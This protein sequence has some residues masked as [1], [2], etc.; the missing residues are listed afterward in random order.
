M[1]NFYSYSFL[2][3]LIVGMFA[4]AGMANTS[5]YSTYQGQGA[6]CASYYHPVCGEKSGTQ[7]VYQNICTMNSAGATFVGWKTCRYSS[8]T[9]YS[10]NY[11][12]T[13]QY[14]QPTQYINT[15][16]IQPRYVTQ[17]V[18]TQDYSPVCAEINGYKKSYSN[19]CF[20]NQNGARVINY[21]ECKKTYTHQCVQKATPYCSSNQKKVFQGNDSYGCSKGYKCVNT[22]TQYQTN[23]SNQY[24]NTYY[25]NSNNYN[26]HHNNTPNFVLSRLKNNR[27]ATVNQNTVFTVNIYA[28]QSGS[29]IT[30]FIPNGI[31]LLNVT[32]GS[33]QKTRVYG[34]TQLKCNSVESIS[35]R[36]KSAYSSCIKKFTTTFSNYNYNS[37]YRTF[38]L[39]VR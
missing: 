29:T 33:C 12:N 13:W 6:S 4:F 23:Y 2:S 5:A 31:E 37:Q 36:A 20:A 7:T 32:K 26:Y 11:V 10:N 17:P 22:Y 24:S 27:A 34:G 30:H 8:N 18:C 14:E 28:G 38:S 3:A 15:Q 1:K 39:T 25:N 16:Y 19:E 9:N 35:Y 21:G